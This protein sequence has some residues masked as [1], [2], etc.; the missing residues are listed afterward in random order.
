MNGKKF[1]AIQRHALTA[2]QIAELEKLGFAETSNIALTL[3]PDRDKLNAELDKLG[4]STGDGVTFVAPPKITIVL[5]EVLKTRGLRIFLPDSKMDPSKRVKTA[6]PP[7]DEVT[8]DFIK[9][10]LSNSVEVDADGNLLALG[11]MQF[12]HI[13]FDEV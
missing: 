3:A 13:K 11:Q 6:F 12:Q 9:K 8:K 10:N 7:I 1:V 4:L 5:V 2:E